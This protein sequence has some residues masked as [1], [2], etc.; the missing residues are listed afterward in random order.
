M[1]FWYDSSIALVDSSAVVLGAA[2]VLF[3]ENLCMLFQCNLGV[4]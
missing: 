2:L 3:I 4:V 1:L